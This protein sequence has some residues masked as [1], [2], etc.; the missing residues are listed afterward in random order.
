M[1]VVSAS[2]SSS[3]ISSN[4]IRIGSARHVC[5]Y[6]LG[7]VPQASDYGRSNLATHLYDL[8]CE[9][10]TYVFQPKID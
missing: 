1:N 2:C 8:S 4:K 5:K 7:T 3:Y 9:I 6:R 10:R